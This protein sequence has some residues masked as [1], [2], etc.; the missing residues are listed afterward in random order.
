M[1]HYQWIFE[2]LRINWLNMVQNRSAFYTMMLL[3][4]LQNLI[5]FGMWIIIFKQISSLKGWGLPEVSYLFAAGAAGYGLFFCLFGGLNQLGH[6]IHDGTLDIYL[7][8][9]RSVLFSAMMQRMRGDSAGDVLTGII[10][11]GL[12]LQPALSMW[13]LI[14]VLTISS[15]AVFASFRLISHSLA[16]WGISGETSENSFTAFLITATNPQVGF[17]PIL[18]LILL[19]VFPAGYIGLLPVEIIRDFRWDFLALQ[20]VGS[21]GLVGVSIWFFNISLRRYCSGSQMT[22]LR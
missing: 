8:R 18:K 14:F 9:P 10:L 15:G 20:L 7:T 4:L 1:K 5:Y 16:F 21:A 13:P 19:T 11:L 12:F 2:T 22:H 17:A 6:M 3:M